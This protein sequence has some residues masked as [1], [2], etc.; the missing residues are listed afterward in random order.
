MY[1][2]QSNRIY[3]SDCNK[4][5]I[6]NN[7]SN[8]LKSKGHSINV[9]KQPCFSCNN[10]I[11]HCNKHELTCCRNKLHLISNDSI[12]TDF[13]NVKNI[14]KNEQPKERVID[15]DIL[16]LRLY[17]YCDSESIIEA[18]SVRQ[19]LNSVMGIILGEYVCCHD[20]YAYIRIKM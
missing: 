18:K 6:P 9:M 11:T 16:L 10:D 8:H 20:G 1:C 2:A 7:Y 4:S 17:N 15:S 5:Y 3:C 12:R 19:K 14:R 13:S